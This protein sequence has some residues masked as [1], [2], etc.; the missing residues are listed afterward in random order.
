MAI[1]E[2][3]TRKWIILIEISI[4]NEFSIN[5]TA[6]FDTGA[7]LNCIKEGLIPTKYYNKTIEKLRSASGNMLNIRYKID[8]IMINKS[9]TISCVLIK[10]LR[11]NMILGTPF[12]QLI[13]PFTVTN[14]RIETNLPNKN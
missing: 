13:Q 3:T 7:D 14:E 10:N 4:N 8:Q 5:T 11:H 6:L 12:I 1:S 9:Y 2:I